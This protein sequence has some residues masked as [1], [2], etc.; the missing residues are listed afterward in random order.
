MKRY[1]IISRK[2]DADRPYMIQQK[3]WL[4]GWELIRTEKFSTVEIAE[5]YIRNGCPPLMPSKF[6]VIKHIEVK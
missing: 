2:Y 6:V 1:R 5:T 4:F 3:H